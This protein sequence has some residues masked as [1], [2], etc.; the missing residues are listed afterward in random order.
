VILRDIGDV[1]G[2]FSLL[3]EGEQICQFLKNKKGLA[4]NFSNQA[5][6]LK[7]Q[8]NRVGAMVLLKEQ[9]QIYRELNDLNAIIGS[10]GN[11]ANIVRIDGDLDGALTLY[12]EAETI[13][14]DIGNVQYL[15]TI[16]INES[17]LF[18][19]KECI[20]EARLAAQEAFKLTYNHGYKALASQALKIMENLRR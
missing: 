7:E 8:G 10:L 6:C 4:D 16:L 15:A 14:R 17:Q 9:E 18:L 11:Q 3:K 2:A 19:E 20:S 12:Q 13:S 1:N 5:L